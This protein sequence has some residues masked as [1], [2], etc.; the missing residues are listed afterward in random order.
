MIKPLQRFIQTI[1]THRRRHTP[2]D[3]HARPSAAND[4]AYD[5]YH[6]QVVMANRWQLAFWL[7]TGVALLLIASLIALLPLKTWDPIVVHRNTQ[8]GEVWVENARTHTL[9]DT[10]AEIES[11]LVRYVVARETVAAVDT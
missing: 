4:W 8:T 9:P 6:S 10:T 11:D 5:Q 7:Q 3:T 1:R 2:P